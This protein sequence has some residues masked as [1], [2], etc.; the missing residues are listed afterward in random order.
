MNRKN[1]ECRDV[2]M[3]WDYNFFLCI[4]KLFVL[5]DCL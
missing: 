1:V 5:F 3:I 2:D 4:L